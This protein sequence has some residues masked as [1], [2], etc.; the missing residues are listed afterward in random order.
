MYLYVPNQIENEDIRR[1]RVIDITRRAAKLKWQLARHMARR[2]DGLWGPE[3]LERRPHTGKRI[4]GRPP[5]RW[6]LESHE[7]SD[8]FNATH[9]RISLSEY[10]SPKYLDKSGVGK[11]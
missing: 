8:S 9:C 11:C 6:T 4:V 3:V 1:T 5:T 2:T 7:S 10:P